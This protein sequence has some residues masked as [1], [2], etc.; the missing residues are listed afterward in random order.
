MTAEEFEKQADEKF[1][2]AAKDKMSP[3]KLAELKFGVKWLIIP[4]AV[5]PLFMIAGIIATLIITALI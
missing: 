3:E 1:G 2:A 5:L 4:L